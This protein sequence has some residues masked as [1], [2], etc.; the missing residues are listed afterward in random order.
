M[1]EAVGLGGGGAAAAN[2]AAAGTTDGAAD[3]AVDGAV[4]GVA[5]GA[6]GGTGEDVWTGVPPLGSPSEVHVEPRVVDDDGWQGGG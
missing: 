3:G 1:A 2:G 4:D 5:D 6:A